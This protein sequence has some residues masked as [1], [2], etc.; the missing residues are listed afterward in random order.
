MLNDIMLNDMVPIYL[1]SF[2]RRVNMLSVVLLSV[3]LLSIVMLSVDLLSVVILSVDMLNV[4]I[5]NA[6]DVR[7]LA[8][9]KASV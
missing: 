2:L 3:D 1:M 8:C 5:L 4:V 6:V 9:Y 7:K